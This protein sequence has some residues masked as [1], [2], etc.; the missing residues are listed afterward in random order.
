[1]FYF[2]P[3]CSLTNEDPKHP[4]VLPRWRRH[5]CNISG[6]TP[7]SSSLYSIFLLSHSCEAAW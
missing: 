4:R 7:T 6:D 1:Y 2:P 5:H 3:L